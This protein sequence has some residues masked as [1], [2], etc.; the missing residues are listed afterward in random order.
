MPW[1]CT[2]TAGGRVERRVGKRWRCWVWERGTEG[3]TP[4]G[5]AGGWNAGRGY[6]EGRREV[7]APGEK[8]WK[9]GDL[10]VL[11]QNAEGVGS[12]D[13]DRGAHPQRACRLGDCRG[14][15]PGRPAGDFGVL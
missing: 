6:R 9:W 8:T 7:G 2:R 10:G 12:G 11:G 3:A 1:R 14:G 4:S 15:V 13:G 5:Q